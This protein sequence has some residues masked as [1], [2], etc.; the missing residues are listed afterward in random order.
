VVFLSKHFIL[1]KLIQTIIVIYIVNNNK[2]SE[3]M[4]KNKLSKTFHNVKS[5]ALSWLNDTAEPGQTAVVM[6]DPITQGLIYNS[7]YQ[8]LSRTGYIENVIGNRCMR[9]TAQAVNSIPFEILINDEPIKDSSDR[10]ARSFTKLVLDPN[11]DYNWK[12]FVAS[13][14]THRF[15]RGRGYVHPEF[16]EITGEP[17]G[18]EFFRPDRVSITTG[19]DERIFSYRYSK[20]SRN[21]VFL[22][23]DDGRF[24][25]ID[26]RAFHPTSDTEGLGHVIPTALSMD[27]HTKGSKWNKQQLENGARNS[28]ILS[29]N[30]GD[31][32]SGF[33]DEESLQKLQKKLDEE[34]S[35]RY[36]TRIVNAPATYTPLNLSP[37]EMDFVDSIKSKAIE[38][39][40][41][42]DYPPYLLGLD[43]ATFNNQAEAKLALYEN[44]AIPKAEEF[45][46]ELSSFYSRQLDAKVEFKLKLK[47]VV[48]LA[49]RFREMHIQAREDWNSDLTKRS[50]ARE[51]IGY[52]ELD[53]LEGDV[54]K[55]DL[56]QPVNLNMNQSET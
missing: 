14:I 41:G 26:W 31:D 40:N 3:I 7:S 30:P 44:S 9:E 4:A 46:L 47:E 23:N 56:K 51:A 39:C 11:A 36:N 8:Q 38:I 53:D 18:I 2:T 17:I 24:D 21:E 15:I 43:G 52:E 5:W 6:I 1:K 20:G 28:G 27:G 49:P 29:I 10:I 37:L 50:E 22:R 34:N 33:L 42:L 25:L 13:V 16:S 12:F 32:Q 48:A 19:Q 55:S 35:K 45:Y 54:F